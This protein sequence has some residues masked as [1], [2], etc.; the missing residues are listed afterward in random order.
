MGRVCLAFR[1]DTREHAIERNHSPTA[2]R[3]VPWS[4]VLPY[5]STLLAVG[6]VIREWWRL[7]GMLAG[8]SGRIDFYR[9]LVLDHAVREGDWWPRFNEIFYHGY[10]SPLFHFYAPLSYYLAEVPLLLGL[11]VEAAIKLAAAVG[12]ALSGL[13]MIWLARDLFG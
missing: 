2:S 6:I 4:R 1:I 8:H 9:Q 10:G 3:R 12:L 11:P 5:A 13:F 7:P